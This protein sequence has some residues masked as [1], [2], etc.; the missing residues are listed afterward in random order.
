MPTT[1]F[2]VIITSYN[3]REFIKDAVGSALSLRNAEKEIIVVDDG[4]SDGSQAIL[5]QYGDA[6]RLIC[7]ESN[8]G[9]GLAANCGAALASGEYL[10][11]LDGDDAFLPWALDVYERIVQAKKPKMILCS[12]WWFK[13]ILPVLQPGDNPR[14]ITSV[15]YQDYLRRDR[16]FVHSAS[17]LVIDRQSF[18]RAQGWS[19]DLWPL[20]DGDM[21]LRLGDCGRTIQIL[22]PPTTFRRIHAAN[23]VNQVP[24]FIRAVHRI[25]RNER[26]G[27]YPGGERRSW[28]R[29]AVIGRMVVYWAKRA[30]KVGLYGD[31]MKLLARGWPM[32]LVK[33]TCRLG[34]VLKAR[35]P[36]ETI[37]I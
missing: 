34:A 17:A 1:R 25:I 14:E 9:H 26:A 12:M 22:A 11:S 19:S 32:A 10:V 21:V 2:S 30:A 28:E 31:A 8:Q 7:F 20:N 13:G 36:C 6:I 35:Q 15:E 5:R 27:K 23:A 3:Q 29:R 16:N 33:V 24:P 18:E 4:S 37:K